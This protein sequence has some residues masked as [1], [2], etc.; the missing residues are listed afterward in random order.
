LLKRQDTQHPTSAG[1]GV[2][3]LLFFGVV[4]DDPVGVSGDF[5]V[6][7]LATVLLAGISDGSA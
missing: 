3:T 5:V 1:D 7:V 4:V 6:L 2:V